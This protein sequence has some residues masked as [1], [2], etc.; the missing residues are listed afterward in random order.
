MEVKGSVVRTIGKFVQDRFPNKYAS[1]KENL[2]AESG[3]IYQEA[4]LATEW[5]PIKEGVIQ[6]TEVLCKMFYDT[7]KEG[8]WESGRYS[9][10]IALTGIYK[11]FVLISTPAFLMNRSKKILSSF[12]SPTEIEVVESKGSSMVVHI[13]KWPQPNQLVEYRIAGWM[14]KALQICGCKNLTVEITKSLTK[15]DEVTE[16]QINWD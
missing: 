8:A 10:Q 12:Y 9:A 13:T 1:W 4:I 2:P 11:V 6:P 3:K 16:F 7:E 15:R 14:E 5:Y